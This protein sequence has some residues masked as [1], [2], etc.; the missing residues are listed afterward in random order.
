MLLYELS[1]LF[2]FVEHL[3]LRLPQH[4]SIGICGQT[5][6]CIDNQMLGEETTMVL[7]GS[8]QT[9]CGTHYQAYQSLRLPYQDWQHTLTCAQVPFSESASQI[10]FS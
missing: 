5:N 3:A 9:P 2:H 6:A 8:D 1:N 10:F 4:H 7:L